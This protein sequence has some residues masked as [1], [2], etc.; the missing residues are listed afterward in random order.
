[1]MNRYHV[2][3]TVFDHNIE[4]LISMEKGGEITNIELR[5]E[6]KNPS[7]TGFHTKEKDA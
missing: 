4:E 6:I 3:K 5:E 2:C 7:E 1:M